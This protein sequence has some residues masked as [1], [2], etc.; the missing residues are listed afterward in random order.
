M[1]I[2]S[3]RCGAPI[4][5]IFNPSRLK[6]KMM[7]A[8]MPTKYWASLPEAEI[9]KD[10]IRETPKRLQDMAEAPKFMAQPPENF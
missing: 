5:T 4:T 7:K 1:K 6:I 10:L 3:M 8:E 2:L 9:I